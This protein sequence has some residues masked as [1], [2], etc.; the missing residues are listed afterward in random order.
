MTHESEGRREGGGIWVGYRG[1][2]TLMVGVVIEGGTLSVG[3]GV[4]GTKGGVRGS[5]EG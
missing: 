1:E 2:G 4:R 3:V 5:G